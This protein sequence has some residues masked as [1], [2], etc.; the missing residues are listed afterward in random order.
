MKSKSLNLFTL[1]VAL[2]GCSSTT[3]PV[4]GAGDSYSIGGATYCFASE[5]IVIETGFNCPAQAPSR[6]DG[7]SG[8]ICAPAG[9]DAK[10]L[11]DELC[12]KAGDASCESLVLV[13]VV[14]ASTQ[15]AS[16]VDD[17]TVGLDAGQ[18]PCVAPAE[19]LFPGCTAPGEDEYIIDEAG[20]CLERCDGETC[21]AGRRC[22]K[23]ALPTC[24]QPGD[25]CDACAAY[26]GVCVDDHTLQVNG[27]TLSNGEG[28]VFWSVS[29]GSPDYIYAFGSFSATDGNFSLSFDRRP[30]EGAL[31]RGRLGVGLLVVGDPLTYDLQAI[32]DGRV[33]DNDQDTVM[34]AFAGSAAAKSCDYAIVFTEGDPA[35]RDWVSRF[36]PGYSCAKVVP[37]AEGESFDTFEPIACDRVD[38]QSACSPPNWT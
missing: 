3:E 18:T 6:F 1:L 19:L 29:S 27:T 25:V 8:V 28:R 9:F 31:N 32:A 26:A 21:G 12:T 15:D 14:D 13:G 2:A 33:D 35:F 36:D 30:P 23:A 37:A 24:D 4:C 20:E 22:V 34:A 38:L 10:D 17:A 16:V 5:A 7:P 11:P